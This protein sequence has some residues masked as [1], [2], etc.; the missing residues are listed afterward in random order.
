MVASRL[1]DKLSAAASGGVGAAASPHLPSATLF[2]VANVCKTNAEC[3][4]K[5]CESGSPHLPS[6]SLAAVASRLQDEPCAA[7]S[8]CGGSSPDLPSALLPVVASRLQDNSRAQRKAGVWERQPP[9]AKRF[10]SCSS[11]PSAR[12]TDRSGKRGYGS[13]S[14]HL[15]SAT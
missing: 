15:T 6:A 1:K 11:E 9:S 7:E 13:G 2:A 8:G 12:Q 3:S 14:L 5:G 4:G 10:G